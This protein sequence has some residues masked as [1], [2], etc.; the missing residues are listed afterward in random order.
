MLGVALGRGGLGVVGFV[1]LFLLS[2]LPE[3]RRTKGG[4]RKEGGDRREN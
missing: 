2:F 1:F 3:R 4:E